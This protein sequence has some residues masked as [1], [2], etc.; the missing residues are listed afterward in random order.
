MKG[1]ASLYM[2]VSPLRIWSLVSDVTQIGRF[3]PETFESQWLG[4]ATGPAVNIRFRGHVRRNGKKWLVYWTTCV[5]TKCEPGR[6]F[7][8]AVL[9]P[10]GQTAV[11]WS[12]CMEPSREG[13]TVTESFEVGTSW[14]LRL[15]ALLA[16]HTRTQTNIDNMVAT[17][18]RIR[19]VAET[20]DE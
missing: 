2:E 9:G 7:A 1:S 10:W 3:S 13:T 4:G 8:F 6:E 15:Y 19:M 18:E 17:L 11:T 12:Y 5:I 16:R 14:A 20:T